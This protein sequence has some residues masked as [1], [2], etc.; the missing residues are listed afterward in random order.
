MNGLR[1]AFQT[2]LLLKFICLCAST[3]LVNYCT[4]KEVAMGIIV[5]SLSCTTY[6][7]GTL[8]AFC[9]WRKQ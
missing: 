8:I 4:N 1:W 9:E 3:A 6:L 2:I 5:V 7:C